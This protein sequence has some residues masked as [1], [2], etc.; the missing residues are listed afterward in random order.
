MRFDLALAWWL[1]RG[2]AGRLWLLIACIAVGIAA[3]VCVGTFSGQ[4]ERALAREARPL[5]G[6]DIEIAANAPLSDDRRA[7]LRAALPSGSRELDQVGFMTM[8]GAPATSKSML[9][10]VRAVDPG[11]PLGGATR[12]VDPVG[13]AV[14]VDVL[15]GAE[16]T[17]L[18]QRS[19]LERLA[20]PIGG[21]LK[22]NRLEL[23][24]AGALIEDPGMGANPFSPGP[25]VLI[26]RQRAVETGL[27]ESGARVRYATLVTC[28]DPAAA[29]RL[30]TSLRERWKLTKGGAQGFGGRI[31][32]ESGVQVRTARQSQESIARFF[33]NLGDF[34]R[35]VSLASLLLG[36]VGVASMIRGFVAER[37]DSVAALQVLGAAPGRVARIFLCQA[38]GIGLAGG[39]IGAGAGLALANLLARLLR[40]YLPVTVDYGVDPGA[41]AWGIALGALTAGIFALLPL[42]EIRRM[43]PL[44][45]MRGDAAAPRARIATLAIL[46][47]T[48]GVFAL[49][50]AIDSRSWRTGPAFVASLAAGALTITGLAR[51]T[52]PLVARLRPPWFGLRHGLGNLGRAGFRPGAALVAIGLAALVI[53]SMAVHQASLQRE[54]DPSQREGVPSLFA[55]DLQTDQRDDFAALVRSAAGA[56]PLLAPVVHGRFRGLNGLAPGSAGAKDRLDARASER[57]EWYRNREQNLSWRDQLGGD[58]TIVAGRWIHD[59]AEHPEASLEKGFADSI[60]AKVGDRI[61]FDVQGV[62]VDAEVTSLRT[63]RWRGMKLNFFIYLSPSALREAPQTWVA[64]VPMLPPDA[65]S[66]LQNEVTARFANVTVIDI[67]DAATRIRDIVDRIAVAIEVM[68]A[69]SLA[70][71][72]VVLVGI[73]LSTARER[74]LDAALIAVLGGRRRTLIAS[75]AVEFGALGLLGALLGLGLAIGFAFVQVQL[76]LDVPV[77]LPWPRLAAIALAITA[78]S[79]AAGVVACRRALTA[80]PLTALRD[81]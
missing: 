21:T 70:A 33:R 29:E 54:L 30:A 2:Q 43:P 59:D 7:D 37:L 61:A 47:F 66:R 1:S 57:G 67:A 74:Q 78:L 55:L 5:L 80:S 24:I 40:G 8:A 58:E 25:R 10:E 38:L 49:L 45:V 34:L 6:A 20:L 75:L 9:I 36:G 35:L 46:A 26:A 16:P 17:A 62:T 23:R 71:G 60:G 64:I 63:V 65:R 11:Y 69:F 41:I 4:V 44:A 13:A 48:L 27:L 31:E 18:V 14:P 76:M 72:L 39:V 12:A 28:A 56:E 81:A 42:H 15:F 22:L 77:A 50:G 79:A 19:V 3:R 51:L 52:L 73:G 32:T 53:G 68:G